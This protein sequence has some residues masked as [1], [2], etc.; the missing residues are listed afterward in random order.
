[1][2]RAGNM[3]VSDTVRPVCISSE[4]A[5]RSLK[6]VICA[7]L[8]MQR[9]PW[10]QGVCAQALYEAGYED[11]W[12]PMAYDA[13]QRIDKDG[14]LAMLGGGEAVSD[15]AA[16]GEVCFRAY[17]KT[18]DPLF[19][20]GAEKMLAY[21]LHKAP[22][23]PDGIICHNNI[24]FVDGFSDCQLWIDGSYMVPPFLAVMGRLDEA[25]EQLRGY[26]KHL[27]DPAGSL[28]YHI[29]DIVQDRFVRKVR[30]ATGNGWA[31][32]GLARVAEEAIRQ[33]RTDLRD[34][35]QKFTGTLLA[36]MLKH[37]LPDGRFH[38]LIDEDDSFIDGTSAMMMAA[39]VYRGVYHSYLPDA[40]R[41]NADHAFQTVTGSIDTYG[42]LRQVC[43]CPDFV[44]EGTSA[45]AQASYIM[46]YAW[47]KRLD[48]P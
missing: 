12:I 26:R 44:S 39:T 36:G 1:M 21:L 41:K 45:E 4:G 17:E 30:W 9:Y 47:K 23:T 40:Y 13:I 8:A 19:R 33:N 28:F 35:L 27:F 46:A 3:K 15:P 38:D 29:K 34:E 42:L 22:R 16:N 10:E 2:E 18:G 7:M 6:K 14:R 5:D 32:M 24:S 20:R 43:G 48:P 25:V 31:L 37:Q 11:L